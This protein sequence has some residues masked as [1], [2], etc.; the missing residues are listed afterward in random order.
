MTQITIPD[1]LIPIKEQV[2]D[3]LDFELKN[4][5]KEKESAEYAAYQFDLNHLKIVFRNA[6]TTPTKAGQFVTLWKRIAGGPIR[7]FDASDEIDLVIITTKA[8]NSFGQ[9]VFPKSV[10]IQQGIISDVKE[11]KRA[12][13]VYPP[14]S[15]TEN[16]QAQQTQKWQL[17]YFLEIPAEKT[18]DKELAEKLYL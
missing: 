15:N 11:G 8:E 10:L 13:R 3:N 4:I 6:K 7:P 9:F 18:I 5:I 12:I 14:W 1:I 17:E 16:K 2:F